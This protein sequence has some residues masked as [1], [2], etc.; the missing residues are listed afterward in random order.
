MLL[1][2]LRTRD[3]DG[4]AKGFHRWENPAPSRPSPDQA[5]GDVVD[6]RRAG[7][8]RIFLRPPSSL[9]DSLGRKYFRHL[10]PGFLASFSSSPTQRGGRPMVRCYDRGQPMSSR[11]SQGD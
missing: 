9:V 3:F 8:L 6:S 2:T 7:L 4:L 1:Q 11:T 5:G 10:C